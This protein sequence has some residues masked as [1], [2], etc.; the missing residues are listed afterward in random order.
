MKGV[1]AQGC[2][3]IMSNWIAKYRVNTGWMLLGHGLCL[4][5]QAVYF[6]II[7]RDLGVQLYGTFVGTAAFAQ[8][9]GPFV[10]FDGGNLLVKSIAQDDRLFPVL[11]GQPVKVIVHPR[12][13]YMRTARRLEWRNI[14]INS[15]RSES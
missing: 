5:M 10:G 14:R 1:A 9:P 8:T 3:T 13:E 12:F 4:F 2:L 7:S 11:L 15:C 6:L